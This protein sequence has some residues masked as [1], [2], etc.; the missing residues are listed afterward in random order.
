MNIRSHRYGDMVNPVE[1]PL[2]FQER[3]LGNVVLE[4]DGSDVTHFET[5]EDIQ[6]IVGHIVIHDNKKLHLPVLLP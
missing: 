1:E 5:L 2:P 6:Q 3:I 4:N